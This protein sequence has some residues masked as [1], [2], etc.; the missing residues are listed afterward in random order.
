MSRRGHVEVCL[1]IAVAIAFV[2]VAVYGY[3]LFG[4]DLD[5]ARSRMHVLDARLDRLE[6]AAGMEEEEGE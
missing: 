4:R 2:A 1:R 3:V 6:A 5:D